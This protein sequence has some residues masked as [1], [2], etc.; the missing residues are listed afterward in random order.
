[1]SKNLDGTV[2]LQS[3]KTRVDARDKIET[4]RDDE[5]SCR[6]HE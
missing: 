4:I 1:M 6:G 5:Y 3:E 2:H